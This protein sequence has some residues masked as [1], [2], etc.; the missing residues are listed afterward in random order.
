MGR[1]YPGVVPDVRRQSTVIDKR[2]PTEFTDIRALPTVDPP[3]APQST[4]PWER[5]STDAAVVR[6]DA[7]VTPHVGLD[8]LIGSTTNVTDF[9]GVPVGLQVVR[10][11]LRWWKSITA[12]TADRFCRV[13]LGVFPQAA[14]T[15]KRLAADFAATRRLS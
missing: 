1:F 13:A 11:H 6:F 14:V 5:L 10:Q 3:V 8:V 12:D 15:L 9:T 2:L 7:G 4:G